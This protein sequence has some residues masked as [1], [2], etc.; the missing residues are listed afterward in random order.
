MDGIAKGCGVEEG[1][2]IIYLGLGSNLGRRRANI[3]SAI[4]LL[5][6]EPGIYLC[7]TSSHYLTEPVGDVEQP[8]CVNMVAEISTSLTPQKFL[9]LCKSIE[10]RLG[11]RSTVRLGPR[12]IDIDLLLYGTDVI[13]HPGLQIP[14]PE[15]KRRRFVIVPLLELDPDLR[16]PVLNLPL[17][18]CLEQ[19]QAKKKVIR[20][21]QRRS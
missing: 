13:E 8:W 21:A 19:G 5:S 4:G 11:R 7:R 10:E 17:C 12:I 6:D 20:L 18:S 1:Q 3:K 16:H 2:K 14:H 9:S 15:L